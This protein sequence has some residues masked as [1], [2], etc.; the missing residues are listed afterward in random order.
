M[1]IRFTANDDDPQSIVEA[2]VDDFLL[3][4]AY[5]LATAIDDEMVP[6]GRLS[7]GPNFPNPFNPV[8]TISFSLAEPG[9][10]QLAVYDVRGRMVRTLVSGDMS[11]G[12]HEVVWQ[13]KDDAG[14][15][16]ASGLYFAR[17]I[18]G[19]RA[20]THKMLMLK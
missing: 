8:T 11:A 9:A 14:H 4:A 7:L 18:N 5:G 20:L 2:G 6:S 15:Q 10:V 13:G 1:K 19:D 17:M 3:D 12:E 16:V